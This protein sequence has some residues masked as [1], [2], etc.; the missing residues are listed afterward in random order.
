MKISLKE[1]KIVLVVASVLALY[2]FFNIPFYSF[3][4]TTIFAGVIYYL[5]G[6][7]FLVVFVY[8][9]PQ[10]IK[11]SN[12][13][14]SNNSVVRDN[15]TNVDNITNFIKTQQEKKT[16]G[17]N[18]LKE[19]SERVEKLKATTMEKID[20]PSGLVDPSLPSGVYPIE[21]TP[22]YPNFMKTTKGVAVNT[23]T[24]IQTIN[25]SDMPVGDL[26]DRN[27]KQNPYIATYDDLSI[28]TALARTTNNNS[29][30]NGST[31]KSVDMT[32]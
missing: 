10:I 8:T 7:T 14:L 11:L 17:F 28:D 21:G 26:V 5:T 24:R 30:I 12:T 4:V 13:L 9:I 31:M 18:N 20:T 32:M 3:L 2:N 27:P 1:D 25:E 22:S 6:S 29:M 23:N 15:F 19:V 16:E